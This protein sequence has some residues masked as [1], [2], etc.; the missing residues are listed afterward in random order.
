MEYGLKPRR[1][2]RGFSLVEVLTVLATAS[3]LAVLTVSSVAVLKSTNLT[4][5]GN[6][7]VDVFAMARQNSIAK[8]D[9]TAVVI[10][11][12]GVGAYRAYC[13]LELT[14]NDDGSFGSWTA[15]T[16]WH[17]LGNGVV[18]QN[19]TTDA[20]RDTFFTASPALPQAL[21]TNFSFQG[22][23]IDLTSSANVAVQCYQSDGTMLGGQSL[24]VRLVEGTV[25]ASGNF[26]YQGTTTSGTQVSY[27]DLVF[28]PNTGVTEIER[29]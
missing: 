20:T 12:S 18:F 19:N 27:Y 21:P 4:T 5:S 23:P 8:N 11:T 7:M 14:R 24:C 22:Q 29:K 13:I 1:H 17:F 28:V 26:S 16:P 15:L 25:D 9:F 3:I 6:Q 10:K 2:M